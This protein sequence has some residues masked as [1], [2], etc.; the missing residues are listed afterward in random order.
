MDS[1]LWKKVYGGSSTSQV[2]N[3][4]QINNERYKRMFK[5]YFVDKDVY[6]ETILAILTTSYSNT[7]I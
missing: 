2:A 5:D 3:I 6:L 1:L 7:N 4:Q